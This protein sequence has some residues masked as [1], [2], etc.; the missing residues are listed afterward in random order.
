MGVESGVAHACKGSTDGG[1]MYLFPDCLK[2]SVCSFGW[3]SYVGC[4]EYGADLFVYAGGGCRVYSTH[5]WVGSSVENGPSVG[6][7]WG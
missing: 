3:Y 2:E 1:G 4:D 6:I 7:L 5:G